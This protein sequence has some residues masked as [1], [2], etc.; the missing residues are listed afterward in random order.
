MGISKATDI[1]R[2]IR[3]DILE[4]RY[5][6]GERLQGER[7]LAD[8]YDANRTSV[9]EALKIVEQEGL[10]QN[11]KG[12]CPRVKS[13]NTA[14]LNVLPHLLFDDN[15]EPNVD[16]FRQIFE[17][18]QLLLLGAI[19]LAIQKAT[20]EQIDQAMRSVDA[21]VQEKVEDRYQH[22][23]ALFS[24]VIDASENIVLK[25]MYNA[26]DPNVQESYGVFLNQFDWANADRTQQVVTEL[27]SALAKRDVDQATFIAKQIII[28]RQRNVL[29]Q[30]AEKYGE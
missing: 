19:E 5:Q 9:R 2:S 6:S 11:K 21:I 15:K 16:V 27:K 8:R 22:I 10:I 17:A 1:A 14:S 29:D 23:H 13:L 18:G 30:M 24:L 25:L 26:I 7:D 12:S 28:H 20:P 3:E 4:G